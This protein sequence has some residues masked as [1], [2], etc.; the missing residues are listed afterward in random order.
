M[1]VSWQFCGTCFLTSLS[2]CS[3]LAVDVEC[4]L[5]LVLQGTLL[6]AVTILCH[7]TQVCHLNM[8]FH[9]GVV[10]NTLAR[11]HLLQNVAAHHRHH[12]PPIPSPDTL[13][14]HAFGVACVCAVQVYLYGYVFVLLLCWSPVYRHVCVCFDM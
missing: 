3:G 11:P 10:D 14:G 4:A 5:G 9:G 1:L 2:F 8:V 13:L 7:G 6:C 12:L